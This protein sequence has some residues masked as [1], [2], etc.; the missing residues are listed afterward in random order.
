LA[1]EYKC[2][3]LVK[4]I[5]SYLIPALLLKRE[6]IRSKLNNIEL[7]IKNGIRQISWDESIELI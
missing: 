4:L 7:N 3:R 2:R 6:G 5:S 1:I